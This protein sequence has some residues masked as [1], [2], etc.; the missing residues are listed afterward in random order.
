MQIKINNTPVDLDEC[1]EYSSAF[2]MIFPRVV[3]MHAY[4]KSYSHVS[5][6]DLMNLPREVFFYFA[7]KCAKKIGYDTDGEEMA[8]LKASLEISHAIKTSSL[9]M[10]DKLELWIQASRVSGVGHLPHTAAD[11]WR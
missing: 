9:N 7:D 10:N 2:D 8:K 4:K 1:Y 11:F 3:A 6:D 5:D